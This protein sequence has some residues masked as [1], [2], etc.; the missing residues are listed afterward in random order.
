[1]GCSVNTDASYGT[2]WHVLAE[3]ATGLPE[4]MVGSSEKTP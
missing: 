1:V 3:K 2:W 4:V